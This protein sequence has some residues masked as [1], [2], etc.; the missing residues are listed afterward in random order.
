MKHVLRAAASIAALALALPGAARALQLE[1]AGAGQDPGAR[2]HESARDRWEQM[3]P[4]RREELLER[5]E[6]WRSL[7]DEERARMRERYQWF[8][9]QRRCAREA[10]PEPARRDLDQL[11]PQLQGEALRDLL[12]DRLSDRG[13]ALLELLPRGMREQL[14]RAS[15]AERERLLERLK[16]QM[17]VRAKERL[18]ELGRGAGVPASELARLRALSP[19]DLAGELMALE[20]REIERGIERRGLPPFVTA[21]QWESWRRLPPPR[22]FELWNEARRR[23]CAFGQRTPDGGRRDGGPSGLRFERL[24]ELRDRLRPDP[25]WWGAMRGLPPERRREELAAKFRA[26]ALEVLG[27]SPELVAPERVR[28]LEE[29]HGRAFFEELAQAVPEIDLPWLER[30]PS[31]EGAAGEEK[32]RDGDGPRRGPRHDAGRDRRPPR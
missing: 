27:R 25:S 2:R 18:E 12:L 24:R 9:D 17:R 31:R 11:D 21:E 28:R 6:R 32:R 1:P 15:P 5:Y 26:R 29:L 22:F 3:P 13:R 14:Q 16:S 10:L 30:L 7:S 4:E 19:R 23:A 8:Q 20:K